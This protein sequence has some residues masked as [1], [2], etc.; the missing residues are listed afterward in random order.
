VEFGI[1]FSYSLIIISGLRFNLKDRKVALP[2]Y[3]DEFKDSFLEV[4]GL[5]A[6]EEH[7][8]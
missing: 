7:L 3:I 4:K 8:T 6:R 5:M 2:K 1:L